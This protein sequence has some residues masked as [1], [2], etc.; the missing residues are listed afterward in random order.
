[1]FRKVISQMSRIN[2]APSFDDYMT[3]S[4]AAEFLGVS[5]A[6]LRNWDRNGKLKPRR[7]PQNGYRIYLHED[8]E[9]VLRSADRPTLSGGS[10]AP[11]VDFSEMRDKEHFV[12]FY[13]NDSYLID[14]VIAF[15]AAALFEGNSSVVIA[16]PEHRGAIQRKLVASGID[17]AD[18]TG[19]GRYVELDASEMLSKFMVEGAPDADRF[20]N[21]VGSVIAR[22][23]TSRGRIHAFGEM[24]ALLWAEGKREAAIQLE[25]LWNQLG[26]RYRF[27][28]F[29]AY[30]IGGFGKE[31]DELAL[32]GVCSCHSRVIPAESYARVSSTD[33]R[34]R[35]IT[36]LQQKAQSLEAEIAHRREV[37]RA[38]SNRE[39]ELS[40]FFENATEGIHKV[41]PNG[42]ILWANKAD[43]E[44]LGYTADEYVG[45]P[46]TDFHADAEVIESILEKL[47]RGETL[48]NFPARL[49]CK[50]GTIKHVLIS[51]NACFEDGRFAY[52][53]C[54]TRDVTRE[55]QA[56]NA[57]RE[58]DRRKDE[59]L[60]TLAHELRNPLAPIRNALELLD[61]ENVDRNLLLEAQSV[62]KRQVGQL[63]RL[64]DDLLDVSRITRDKL[65][66][67]TEPIEL[68]TVIKEAVETSRPLIDAAGHALTLDLP[69]EE[70]FINADLARM[71][72]V[73]SNLLNNSAKYTERGG[74]IE[75]AA[76]RDGAEIAVTVRDNGI[77]IACE[78]LANVF[79]M[80][81]QV[82]RSLERSQGGLGIGLTLVRRLV[83][84][85][86]GTVD[87]QSAGLGRGSEF[88]VRLPIATDGV[89]VSKAASHDNGHESKRLRILVADDNKDAGETLSL[90][91]RIKGHHVR[92]VRD[93]M[94]AVELVPDFRPQVVLMDIGMPNLNGYDATRAIRETACGKDSFIVAL[95]GW[96]QESD[97]ERSM[98]AGCSAHL[99]KPVDLAALEQMIDAAFE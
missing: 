76:W 65:D 79:D 32:S 48:T 55:W 36:L 29:C 81:R 82:D 87:A 50:N 60:A 78:E 71:S 5:T 51:S 31:S 24:V 25:E 85:H 56:E 22:Q 2:A 69:A 64:V 43:Y 68:A 35:A 53:R 77:G 15:V 88:T 7:H 40:D 1:M 19:S 83:E 66:L 98:E 72:Q 14:S 21:T 54:F 41:G 46:I 96:G 34:L 28:L 42:V 63:T 86:G 16:T 93:G 17:I 61:V 62:M 9:A 3:V 73:F 37:E 23:A 12:Q 94:E 58:S 97:I 20:M 26:K 70:I 18:A 92:T 10:L 91:L 30:P 11:H 67:R 57:L 80:F 90:Y 45:R 33:E 39:R 75:I 27:A 47:A 6:T 44:L 74:K 49:H 52:T 95:T 89:L 4:A 8:L 13:D 59:F 84:L 99:V 38:L